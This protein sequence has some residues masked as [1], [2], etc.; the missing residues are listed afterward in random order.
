MPVT[1]RRRRSRHGADA[2]APERHR[3]LGRVRHRRRPR[4][5]T[6]RRGTS[7]PP[8][9]R[10]RRASGGA[11]APSTCRRA[12]APVNASCASVHHHANSSPPSPQPSRPN[13][14]ST[15]VVESSSSSSRSSVRN[16][17]CQHTVGF[18]SLKCLP[19]FIACRCSAQP[20]PASKPGRL[21]KTH[22]S[23]TSRVRHSSLPALRPHALLHA[24]LLE[25]PLVVAELAWRASR[26]SS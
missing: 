2:R 24:D 26:P 23:S 9:R 22:A 14:V 10:R 25:L 4:V 21:R 15:V 1:A 19:V 11:R 16:G 13:S 12:R 7:R 6:R 20:G 3:H 18:V 8:R 5:E 17:S